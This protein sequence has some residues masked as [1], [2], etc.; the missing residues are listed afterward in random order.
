[1]GCW[2]Q[3]FVFLQLLRRAE[4]GQ[5]QVKT[6]VPVPAEREREQEKSCSADLAIQGE[7]L[8][9]IDIWRRISGA[10]ILFTHIPGKHAST[11]IHLWK[12]ADKSSGDVGS[13][14]G[15]RVS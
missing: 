6:S 10:E 1:M 9:R 3:R 15:I 8:T 4:R 5:T 7:L 12:P 11:A 13:E 2:G 14:L